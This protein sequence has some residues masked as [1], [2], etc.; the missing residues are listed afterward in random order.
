MS[1]C[2][3]RCLCGT[4]QNNEECEQGCAQCDD[5][6]ACRFIIARGKCPKYVADEEA[7]R[8]TMLANFRDATTY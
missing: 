7:V 8:S 5:L 4:C 6:Q 1:D 3:N 2:Y